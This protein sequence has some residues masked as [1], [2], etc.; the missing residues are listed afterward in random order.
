M[1]YLCVGD[2]YDLLDA[3]A[4]FSTALSYDNAGLL[5][6]DRDAPAE[7]IMTT[8]D[9]TGQVVRN[10]SAAGCTLIV[11]HH[12]VIFHPLRRLPAGS[13]PALLIRAGIAAICAHTNL[14]A[15]A[16][17]VNDVLCET[18]ALENISRLAD[19]G[20][21]DKPPLARMGTLRF[22]ATADQLAAWVSEKLQAK[23]RVAD[24]GK[25]IRRVAVCGGAGGDFIGP[26]LQAGADALITGELRYHDALDAR[27]AGFTVIEAGHFAT[28]RGI[29]PA[30]AA[31]IRAAFPDA[32]VR[33][34]E[35]TDPIQ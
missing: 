33:E 29:V 11:S 15:A 5:A 32:V 18:L 30:I 34:A 7:R 35:E 21:P 8:L 4:P 24:G 9:I 23:V 25:P 17:G 19:P 6:G 10:A 22:S 16:G 13:V 26:A 1:P 28:E 3:W 31:R 12:P 20:E 27:E 2:V 14:D